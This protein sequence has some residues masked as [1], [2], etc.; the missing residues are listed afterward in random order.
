MLMPCWSTAQLCSGRGAHGRVLCNKQQTEDS[1]AH[2]GLL[3]T[4]A[5]GSI[6]SATA[7]IKQHVLGLK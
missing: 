6:T 4:P 7:R 1:V 2:G 3:Y 5:P